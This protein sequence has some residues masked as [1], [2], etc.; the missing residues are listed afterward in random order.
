[1]LKFLA[2]ILTGFSGAI[3]LKEDLSFRNM[4]SACKQY[5]R[6][7]CPDCYWQ[8]NSMQLLWRYFDCPTSVYLWR[9]QRRSIRGSD[10]QGKNAICRVWGYVV[11]HMQTPIQYHFV[12]L[13]YLVSWAR[14][15]SVSLLPSTPT[16]SMHLLF[17]SNRHDPSCNW[18]PGA[19]LSLSRSYL[20]NLCI[21][22]RCKVSLYP[23]LACFLKGP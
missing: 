18:K 11:S 4:L 12:A 8:N 20:F 19:C 3:F 6:H 2:P 15:V 16:F 1:M 23:G 10:F 9:S 14:P 7:T 5:I 22:F 21:W 17:D 13:V